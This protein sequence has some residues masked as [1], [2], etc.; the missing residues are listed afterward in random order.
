[1]TTQ[2][3]T[4]ET[5]AAL[6]QAIPNPGGTPAQPEAVANLVLWLASDQAAYVNGSSH[7]VDAGI[8][9]GFSLPEPVSL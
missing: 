7:V 8:T 5:A 2:G 1:M 9:A 6:A 3:L 4:E